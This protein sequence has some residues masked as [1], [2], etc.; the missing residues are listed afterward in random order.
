MTMKK[1]IIFIS[2][3]FSAVS[4]SAQ[5]LNPTLEVSRAYEGKLIEVHKPNIEMQVPDTVRNFNLKFDYSVFDNPY[6]SSMEFNPYMV[7]M[8][9]APVYQEQPALYLL[10]GAGYTL[11]PVFDLVWSPR[12]KGPFQLD[13][14]AA[15]R[16][17]VG[18]Y[19]ALNNDAD[20]WGYDLLSKAGLDL[21]YDWKKVSLE[22]GA[23]YYGVAVKDDVKKRE[24]NALD[25]YLSLKSKSQWHKN[26][27]YDIRAAYRFAEDRVLSRLMEHD[28]RVDASFGP[29]FDD[30]N[31]MSFDVG[32]E[33][34]AYSKAF[35]ETLAK[36]YFTPRY[37]YDKGIM[38]VDLGVCVSASM[39]S[40]SFLKGQFVYPDL[41]LDLNII[42]KALRM[43]VAVAGGEKLNTYASL[44]DS[45][46]HLDLGYAVSG[47]GSLLSPTVERVS[48]EL[49]FEGRIS[50]F[51]SYN[52]MGGYANF[53]TAPFEVAYV[54]AGGV[55]RPG[56]GYSPYQKAY[57]ELNW[58]LNFQSVRF[59]GN[60]KYEYSWGFNDP[61]G[62][63]FEPSE[64]TANAELV[65]NWKKRLHVGVDCDFATARCSRL[66]GK[67]PRYVDLGAFAEYA[68][69]R[70]ISVWL[71]G[72]NF[73]NMEI[74]RNMFYA[75]KGI[76]FTAGICL[77][78]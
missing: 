39:R 59:D 75:E 5:N 4:M 73:L 9:P 45:N 22:M 63:L 42:P 15:H 27:V 52:L 7:E 69:N 43:H 6:R 21:T 14:H 57:A 65:Y 34:D 24:Y 35:S 56:L 61:A 30:F 55:M 19:R 28:F 32:V 66:A 54:D 51:F 72:G 70:K 71:R 1:T 20:W 3:I 18:N 49:G 40:A 31:K 46:H 41:H 16:S 44:I 53:M 29:N 12:M 77:G 48:T 47:Y 60:V 76:N 68:I 13:V 74:Q 23:S 8:R 33:L 78:L 58:D 2:I 17:Y 25:A 67:I 10:A 36:F 37:V 26:F 11:H 38:H 62:L 50:S 64:L